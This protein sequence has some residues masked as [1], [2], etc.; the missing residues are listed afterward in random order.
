MEYDEWKEAIIPTSGR[1]TRKDEESK[2]VII[3]KSF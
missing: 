1:R 3:G 2:G